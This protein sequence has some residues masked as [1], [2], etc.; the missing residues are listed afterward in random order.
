[1]NN[2]TIKNKKVVS[3]E[4]AAYRSECSGSRGMLI[5][6]LE[7]KLS[8]IP[9]DDLEHRLINYG[10]IMAHLIGVIQEL[11]TEIEELKKL[12]K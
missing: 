8:L 5:D 9:N 10:E 11:N 1:M 6:D 2:I 7:K 12:M 3:L 4:E